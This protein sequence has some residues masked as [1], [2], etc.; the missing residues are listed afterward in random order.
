[1]HYH[2][3]KYIS[4][5]SIRDLFHVVVCPEHVSHCLLERGLVIG[6]VGKTYRERLHMVGMAFHQCCQDARVQPTAQVCPHRDIGAQPYGCGVIE[7]RPDPFDG[8]V[9]LYDI[10]F[11]AGRKHH[12]PVGE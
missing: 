10:V 12:V 11:A 8:M 9:F 5:V 6:R 3:G 4:N 7:D 1:M 2:L